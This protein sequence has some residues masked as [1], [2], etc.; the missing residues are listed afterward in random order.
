MHGVGHPFA[1]KAFR[2]FGLSPFVPTLSQ[3]I[4]D[5]DFPTVAFPNPEEGK[6]ALQLA[7]KTAQES[8]ATIIL[9]N[10]PDGSTSFFF[11]KYL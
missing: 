2:T 9:A 4:P 10:D 6:G 11:N 7:M 8:G 5:P 3:I 1:V